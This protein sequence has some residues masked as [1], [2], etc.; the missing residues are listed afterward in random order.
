MDDSEISWVVPVHVTQPLH[1][2]RGSEKLTNSGCGAERPQQIYPQAH[3]G[4][5]FTRPDK[6]LSSFLL[7]YFFLVLGLHQWCLGVTPISSS[8]IT[9]GGA[10][11]IIWDACVGCMEGKHPVCYAT[12]CL[13]LLV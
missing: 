10:Q 5:H 12:A 2:N 6:Q 3:L 11:R 9:P 1:R 13:S 4:A 7:V 8:E